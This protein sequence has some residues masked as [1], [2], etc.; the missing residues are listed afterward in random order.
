MLI[1]CGPNSPDKWYYGSV[2][3]ES[4]CI[5]SWGKTIIIDRLIDCK[6]I[7]LESFRSN[8]TNLKREK[9]KTTFLYTSTNYFSLPFTSPKTIPIAHE[10]INRNL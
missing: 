4:P 8:I 2:G 6:D 5:H 1:R 7:R 10:L 3:G 9:Y